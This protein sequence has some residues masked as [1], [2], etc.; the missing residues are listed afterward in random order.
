ML[1]WLRVHTDNT[2]SLEPYLLLISTAYLSAVFRSME[3]YCTTASKYNMMYVQYVQFY[4]FTHAF[5]APRRALTSRVE[6]HVRVLTHREWFLLLFAV[7]HSIELTCHLTYYPSIHPCRTGGIGT[8]FGTC[9]WSLQQHT[10]SIYIIFSFFVL[11]SIYAWTTSSHLLPDLYLWMF[12]A[13]KL[14]RSQIRHHRLQ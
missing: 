10:S 11:R 3:L 2:L 12:P 6:H 1:H 4:F 9:S 5:R 14:E 7:G 13:S 8:I